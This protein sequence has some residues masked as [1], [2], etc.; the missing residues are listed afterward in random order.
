M[1][2]LSFLAPVQRARLMIMRDHL[3]HRVHEMRDDRQGYPH[4]A[5]ED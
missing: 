2:K 1:G 3:L 4:H 5:H